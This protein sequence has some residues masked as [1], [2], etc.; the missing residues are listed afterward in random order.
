MRIGQLKQLL[1]SQGASFAPPPVLSPGRVDGRVSLYDAPQVALS[2]MISQ[3][4]YIEREVNK[5]QYPD[6]QYPNLIP[7]DTSAPEWTPSITYF[8]TD[9]TGEAKFIDSFSSDIPNADTKREKFKHPIQMAAIGYG[10]SMEELG[11]AQMLGIPLQPEKAM[12][13]RRK[14]EEFVDR[15]ALSGDT[16]VNF[17]GLKNNSGITPA[18][19]ANDGTGSSRLWTAKTST[20]ILRDLNEPLISTRS[21]SLTVEMADTM[22]MSP[23]RI[24]YLASTPRSDSSDMTILEYFRKN[25]VYTAQT[26]QP[27]TIRAMRGLETAGASSTQRMITYRRSPE[28]LKLHIPMTHRFLTPFQKSPLYVEVP[29]IFRLGGLEIKRP[30]AVRYR[31][32]F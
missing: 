6:I 21:V 2:F 28:V 10:Y 16:S 19:V 25:N 17:E 18:N 14:Y 13:A 1:D 5:V 27:L 15:V 32:G 8:S 22:L 20:Q 7:V 12:A 3:A 30:G 26:G 9:M 4:T 24:D 29:G 31:D 23:G 11:Q